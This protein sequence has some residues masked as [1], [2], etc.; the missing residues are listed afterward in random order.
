MIL[1]QKESFLLIFKLY[2][3]TDPDTRHILGVY[4]NYDGHNIKD[5]IRYWNDR[6]LL[7]LTSEQQ[8]IVQFINFEG[9]IGK[10]MLELFPTLSYDGFE[11]SLLELVFDETPFGEISFGND[12]DVLV[13]SFFSLGVLS[14]SKPNHLQLDSAEYW[15]LESESQK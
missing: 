13:D 9:Q 10:K 5:N 14:K 1:A 7:F 3:P 15:L 11:S 12:D 4:Y 2:K 8:N 6:C